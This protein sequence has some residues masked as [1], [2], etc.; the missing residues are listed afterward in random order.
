MAKM[1]APPEAA[2]DADA[3]E[4]SF[5]DNSWGNAFAIPSPMNSPGLDRE[6]LSTSGNVIVSNV[7]IV[8]TDCSVQ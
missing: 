3:H 5:H 1:L 2:R 4:A 7:W 6:I 8:Q